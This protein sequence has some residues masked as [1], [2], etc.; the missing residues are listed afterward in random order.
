MRYSREEL[1]DLIKS[2]PEKIS[3]SVISRPLMQSWL[4]PVVA[5][6]A[7]PAEIAYWSQLGTLF[8]CLQLVVPVVYPRISASILEPKIV[9]Y[10]VK[11]NPEITQ[12][13]VNRQK[14]IDAYFKNRQSKDGMNP[15]EQSKSQLLEIEELYQ[16][17]LTELDPTL[18]QVSKKTFERIHSLLQ[19]IEQKTIKV[20][21]QKESILYQNLTQIHES[22]FPL[23]Q[24]Q[25]RFISIIYFLNKFGPGILKKFAD[26][27]NITKFKHQ[28]I[29][30]TSDLL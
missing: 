10:I 26:K 14:F 18:L 4:M 22:I 30:I 2:H 28:L 23:G 17:Y 1:E 20:R 19:N 11:H 7:G 24:P 29:Y 12:L 3:T 21:E 6:I 13:S 15:F 27:I 5:Y 9:R 16:A 8:D 25:E